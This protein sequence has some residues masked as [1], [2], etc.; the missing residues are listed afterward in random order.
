MADHSA[1]GTDQDEDDP[2]N[3][4]SAATQQS[5][6]LGCRHVIVA[7]CFLLNCI[8]YADR[9][10]LSV[11]LVAMSREFGWSSTTSGSLLA[12]FFLGY[13]WTQIPGGMAAARYGAKPVLLT[14]VLC[15]SVLTLVTPAAARYS[16]G[17]L[18]SVRV[19]VGLAEG[20]S[21][22]SIH[23]LLS[24]WVPAGERSRA[25][26]LTSSGQ[27]LGTVAAFGCARLVDEW[28]PAIFYLFGSLGFVWAVAFAALC[29]SHPAEHGC[30]GDAELQLV[31]ARRLARSPAPPA[32]R[33][34]W[35]AL[36]REPAFL[37]I[38]AA[39]FSMNWGSYLLLSW[40]PRYLVSLGARL[41]E[42]GALFSTPYLAAIFFG[43][44]GGWVADEVLLRRLGCSLRRVRKAIQAAASTVP[45]ACFL[46]LCGVAE[47]ATATA[48]LTVAICF[49]S[50]THSAC[51]ANILD[52]TAGSA[53]N[54]GLLMGVA[55]TVGT[56]P[57]I[58]ANLITGRMLGGQDDD[59]GP[60]HWEH[61]FGLGVA[62]YIAGLV[63]YLRY[64][65]GQP[66][67]G[68]AEA[69]TCKGPH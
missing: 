45:A 18:W 54:A 30:I 50:L 15:W 1:D 35:R 6:T 17:A 47:P 29:S 52:L 36:L 14:G 58:L 43:N 46:G 4:S 64:A 53:A 56:L 60:Q 39:H 2:L 37:C 22:P 13:L 5:S 10:N 27:F 48:L 34:A 7:L 8:S 21:M 51:L 61:V 63:V 44:V 66:I 42:A 28:W 24:V 65:Q 25:L 62:V 3:P 19:L 40:L 26:A 38:C 16:I 49:A 9:T 32:A 12:A 41:G 68:G 33:L 59:G 31:G 57:G 11:A 23:A 69:S 67:F 20:V 55:N